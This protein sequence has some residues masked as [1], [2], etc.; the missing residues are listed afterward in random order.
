MPQREDIDRRTAPKEPS[1]RGDE[2][3]SEPLREPLE[4]DLKTATQAKTTRANTCCRARTTS[5]RTEA[6]PEEDRA[7]DER[8]TRANAGSP[9]ESIPARASAQHLIKPGI[10]DRQAWHLVP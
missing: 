5:L 6:D 10:V 2:E 1:P 7:A 4:A 9:G 3:G 8:N